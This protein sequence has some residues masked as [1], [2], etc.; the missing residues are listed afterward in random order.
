MAVSVT[1]NSNTG[2]FQ[3]G[4]FNLGPL[5]IISAF[6]S[7]EILSLTFAS[8]TFISTTG[9]AGAYGVLVE[10]PSNNLVNLTLKGITGDTGLPTFTNTPQLLTFGTPA[11]AQTVGITSAAQVTAGVVTLTFF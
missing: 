5:T 11:N 2:T 1:L 7:L 8:A 9:P 4:T 3:G 6:T 10:P